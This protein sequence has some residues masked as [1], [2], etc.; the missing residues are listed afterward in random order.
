MKEDSTAIVLVPVNVIESLIA[1][2]TDAFGLPCRVSER[3]EIHAAAYDHRRSQCRGAAMMR[4]LAQLALPDG[5]HALG[6]IDADCCAAGLNFIFGQA[7]RSGRRAF[8]ALPRLRP[9]FYGVAEDEGLFHQ[10]VLKEAVHELGHTYGLAHCRKPDCV[11]H[12]SHS[13]HDTD[14]KGAEFCPRC[15]M[16]LEER[17]NG[18]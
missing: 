11:M 7:Q 13:L 1:P 10:P 12:F 15:E 9:S 8:I 16:Q 5:E 17:R 14:V 18:R 4:A 2:V 3:I 6:L